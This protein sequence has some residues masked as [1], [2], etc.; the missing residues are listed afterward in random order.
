MPGMCFSFCFFGMVVPGG[1][2]KTS[3]PRRE[4]GVHFR[5]LPNGNESSASAVAWCLVPGKLPRTSGHTRI[6]QSFSRPE[7]TERRPGCFL[8]DSGQGRRS[9][10]V[11]CENFGGRA[12]AGIANDLVVSFAATKF[13]EGLSLGTGRFA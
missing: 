8:T 4:D 7:F 12:P 6:R 13:W 9:A 1:R 10:S 11:R 3:L 2:V 5:T